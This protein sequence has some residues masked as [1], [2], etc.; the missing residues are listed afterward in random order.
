MLPIDF[1]DVLTR[2]A[3]KGRA[4]YEKQDMAAAGY[5]VDRVF[6]HPKASVC[7]RTWFFVFSTYVNQVWTPFPFPG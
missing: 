5:I 3:E 4:F 2:Q 6:M 7:R 1:E